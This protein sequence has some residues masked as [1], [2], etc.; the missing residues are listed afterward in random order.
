MGESPGL[1]PYLLEIFHD[2]YQ[3][4]RAI[5]ADRSQLSLDTFPEK[6]MADIEKILDENWFPVD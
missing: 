1:K 2:C 6:P 5:A 4:G 3:K